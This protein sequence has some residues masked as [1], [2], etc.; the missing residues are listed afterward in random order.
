MPTR[1]GRTDACPGVLAVHQA[2]DGGVARVRVPG[3]QLSAG[4]FRV[5]ATGAAELGDGTIELTSRANLQVR[6]LAGGAERTLG[7][8]LA[9]VGLLPSASHEKVRN[10]V[11]SPLTGR[12]DAG[13]ADVR[14]LVAD[15]DGALRADPG[16]AELPGRFLFAL[17]D[18]RGD[19]AWLDA[20]IAAL[21][22]APDTAAILLGGADSGVRVPTGAAGPLMLSCA[23]T[24]LAVRAGEWRVAELDDGARL[25]IAEQVG[26]ATAPPVSGGQPTAAG[27]LGRV[28]QVDGRAALVAG[29]PLGSLD[30][31]QAA[32]LADVGADLVVTP[33]RSVVVA[34]LSPDRVEHVAEVLLAAGLLLDPAA[35]LARVTACTGRPG[36]A[37]ALA[38]VRADAEP[39]PGMDLPVHW[40][41]CGRR[42][43]RP[44]GEVVD[45]VANGD[46]YT[47]TRGDQ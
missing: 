16:F 27:P 42:C 31:A 23:N 30:R 9:E 45:V 13:L 17:D 34:D 6:G 26:G 40:S 10:I 44:R 32:A 1:N 4:A 2:A 24:F 33:W 41:G 3:G 5:V 37:K 43:G 21:L 11:A 35:P 29:A 39:L 25:R 19:V 36:C 47:M 14:R 18:G 22:T 12:D 8:A 38:D 46:G 28:D 15:L 7:A 20:D